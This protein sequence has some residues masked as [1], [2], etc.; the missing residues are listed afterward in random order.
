M[1]VHGAWHGAWCWERLV[2][3][4]DALGHRTLTVDLPSDDPAA[5]FETYADHVIEAMSS[6]DHEVIV[7]G[8]SMAGM[9]IPL[10]AARRPVRRLVFLCALIPAPGSSL[11]EQLSESDVLLPDY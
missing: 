10:V 7:V 1:L 5:T 6:E 9:T 8:H 2:P 3:E 4:L 11:V